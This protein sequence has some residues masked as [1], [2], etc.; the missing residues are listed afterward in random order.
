VFIMMMH[1]CA[2]VKM[3]LKNLHNNSDS[4]KEEMVYH[5]D[6]YDKREKI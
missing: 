6:I 5:F 2:T 3:F 1:G 4:Q